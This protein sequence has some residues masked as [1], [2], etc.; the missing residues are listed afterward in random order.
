MHVASI[1]VYKFNHFFRLATVEVFKMVS[2]TLYTS[3][4][5]GNK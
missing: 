5:I 4:I 2:E 1:Q 3:D